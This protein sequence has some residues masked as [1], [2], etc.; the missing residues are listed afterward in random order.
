MEVGLPP[1]NPGLVHVN[2][3]AGVMVHA[4]PQATLLAPDA[5][6]APLHD[7]TPVLIMGTVHGAAR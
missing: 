1:H 7:A 4:V 6:L 3:L 2:P 5:Q